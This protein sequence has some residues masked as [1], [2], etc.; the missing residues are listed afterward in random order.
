MNNTMA[1]MFSPYLPEGI[2]YVLS[3][4]R[5]VYTADESDIFVFLDNEYVIKDRITNTKRLDLFLTIT[6]K[7]DVNT[8]VSNGRFT[9]STIN[10]PEEGKLKMVELINRFIYACDN[11]NSKWIMTLEDDVL[12][13]KKI[14]KFPDTDFTIAKGG[15]CTGGII[16]DREKLSSTLKSYTIDELLFIMQ[17]Y[18]FHFAGDQL[19][20]Y[21]LQNR[22]LSCSVFQDHADGIRPED[23]EAAVIHC[24]KDHYPPYYIE[25]RKYM[26]GEIEKDP[27]PFN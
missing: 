13:R 20:K 7:Y 24:M 18:P 23:T 2:D 8:I 17:S 5:N 1:F 9:Y 3:N 11:T 12:I 22:G 6:E 27:M 4:I 15:L 14:T 25:Y 26:E 21:L 16:F 19:I 10:F